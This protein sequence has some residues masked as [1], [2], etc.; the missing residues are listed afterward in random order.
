MKTTRQLIESSLTVDEIV[1]IS[2]NEKPRLTEADASKVFLN[3]FLKEVK[4]SVLPVAQ[5]IVNSAEESQLKQLNTLDIDKASILKD[6][7]SIGKSFSVNESLITEGTIMDVIG[8]IKSKSKI[9]VAG[10]KIT[11]LS[12]LKKLYTATNTAVENA[13][14]ETTKQLESLQEGSGEESEGLEFVQSLSGLTAST[15]AL[16]TFLSSHM[17]IISTSAASY[18]FIISGIAAVISIFCIW[19]RWRNSQKNLSTAR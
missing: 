2:L 4:K 1:S 16:V 8:Q 15:L 18:G 10:I 5:T 9:L 3:N 17:H 11:P 12:S 14:S 7:T 6:V 19:R 13:F